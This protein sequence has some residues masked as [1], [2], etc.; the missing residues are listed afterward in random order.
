[1]TLKTKKQKQRAAS[2]RFTLFEIIICLSIVAMLASVIGWN[3][4]SSMRLY[5]FHEGFKKVKNEIEAL[6]LFS[7]TFG[8]DMELKF[9]KRQGSWQ[10]IPRIYEAVL[11]PEHVKPLDLSGVDR[12]LWQG[13]ERDFILKIYASGRIEPPGVLEFSQGE[14][15]YYLDLQT[16]LLIKAAIQYPPS[17]QFRIPKRPKDADPEQS[18]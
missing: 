8:S 11:D 17:F 12:L 10:V 5:R 1:M 16:P 9:E 14:Q 13:I 3:V 6:Q 4:Y 15:K 7:L 18:V 2:R